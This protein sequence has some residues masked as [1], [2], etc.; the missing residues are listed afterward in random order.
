MS[1]TGLAF[2]F[3]SGKILQQLNLYKLHTFQLYLP[4]NGFAALCP[5]SEQG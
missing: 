5:R 4:E 2:S 3:A 1:G